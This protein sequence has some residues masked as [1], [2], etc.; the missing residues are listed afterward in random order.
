MSSLG[1]GVFTEGPFYKQ[2]YSK[3]RLDT[4]VEKKMSKL[5]FRQSLVRELAT[6]ICYATCFKATPTALLKKSNIR[7]E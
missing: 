1:G 2:K 7:P 6:V 5:G 4:E 3:L